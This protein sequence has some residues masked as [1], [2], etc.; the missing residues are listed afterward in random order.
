MVKIPENSFGREL[1]RL[2][3]ILEESSTNVLSSDKRW[4]QA[5][6]ARAIG[7]ST[8]AYQNWIHGRRGKQ[9]DVESIKKLSDILQGDFIKLLSL[10]RPDIMKH[11]WTYKSEQLDAISRNLRKRNDYNEEVANIADILETLYDS[12]VDEFYKLERLIKE[13][14]PEAT[15]KTERKSKQRTIGSKK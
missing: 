3:K 11:L 1:E 10:A 5:R 8:Q 15:E 6:V 9:M 14:Y 7:V 13:I 4:S 12:E 2:R